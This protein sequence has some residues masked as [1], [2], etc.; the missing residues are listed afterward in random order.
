MR[1]TFTLASWGKEFARLQLADDDTA[2]VGTAFANAKRN[3]LAGEKRFPNVQEVLGC[4]PMRLR[5][6]IELKETPEAWAARRQAGL[7]QTS[8]ILENLKGVRHAV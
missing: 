1:G 2:R 8:R 4:L 3:A 5:E 6:R 7:T